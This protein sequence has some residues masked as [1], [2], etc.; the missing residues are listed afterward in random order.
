MHCWDLLDSL[1]MHHSFSGDSTCLQI[2]LDVARDWS[3]RFSAGSDPESLAWYDMAVGLR[4]ARLAYLADAASRCPT[5]SDADIARLLDLAQQHRENLADDALF[6]GHNNHGIYQAAGQIAMGRRLHDVPG[7][8]ELARQGKS[9][10]MTLLDLQ[11]TMEGV[12]R[13]HSPDY[14]RMVLRTLYALVSNGLIDELGLLKELEK[15]EEALSWFVAP[16]ARLANLG[17]SDSRDLAWSTDVARRMWRTE[18]MR[19]VVTGGATGSQ[20]A[21]SRAFP[22]SGYFVVRHPNPSGPG[23]ESYLAFVAAFHS[24]VHKHADDLSLIWH[25]VG[26]PI[27]ID[28]GRYGYL[29]KTEPGSQL[30]QEG[31]WYSAPERIYV[32]STHAHNCVEIDGRT[33]PRKGA[34]SYGSAIARCGTSGTLYFCEAEYRP[35]TGLRHARTLILD[36]GRWLIVFDWLKD[37]LERDHAWAQWF[38]F[39]PGSRVERTDDRYVVSCQGNG[40]PAL[41]MEVL[42]LAGETVLSPVF[43]GA[44]EPRLQGWWSPSERSFEPAPAVAIQG[45]NRTNTRVFATL[46]GLHG[47]ISN[48][49][50]RVAPSGRNAT[51]SW[52]QGG[53]GIRIRLKRRASGDLSL[54]LQQSDGC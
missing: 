24:R 32:E 10:L 4:A 47:P 20:S 12:H 38:H 52:R 17:D 41:T 28:A 39:A 30:W 5:V 21:S 54:S 6:K 22:E 48:A 2:A 3:A 16:N 8:S 42:S 27:L 26:R 35:Q 45:V 43:E 9:R 7:M 50:A 15:I 51:F 36:P 23:R 40:G 29:G 44:R 34:N 1:L 46:L 53:T 37:N 18:A 11:F 19:W 13:E 31:Y 14:H 25:E 49:V 33:I